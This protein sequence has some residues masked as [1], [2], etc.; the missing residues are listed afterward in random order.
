MSI[1]IEFHG[2]GL[3]KFQDAVEALGEGKATSAYR[4]ALNSTGKKV[5]TQVKR[6]VAKQMGTSQ[7]NVV[8]HGGM[9]RV[10][11][12]GA[13]LV[14]TIEA[15]GNYLPLSDFKSRQVGAGA[16]AAP[17]ATRR[18]FRG[19]FIIAKLGGNVFRRTGKFSPASGRHNAIEK[20]WGPAVPKEMVRDESAATFDRVVRTELA[21]E[22]N[23]LLK[24]MSNGAL[25]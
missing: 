21:P 18:I 10:P 16:S 5:F 23:R 2:E 25:S 20:L 4:K 22:V 3:P 6:S 15:K 13:H 19:T 12:S 9:K 11:A 17:W 1:K 7:R 14:T 24:L 8:K